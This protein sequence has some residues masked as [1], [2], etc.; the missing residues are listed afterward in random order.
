MDFSALYSSALN[1]ARMAESEHLAKYG[2]QMYCGFAWVYFPSARSPFVNFLKKAGIGRAHWKKGY[3][4]WN[5]S[6]N[7]SQSMDL[8]EAGADAF[9]K[10]ISD[11]GIQCYAESRA[12]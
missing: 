1:S 9:A 12:D 6:G 11:A 4:I 8:K 7:P 10:V 3:V 5:P 2:E